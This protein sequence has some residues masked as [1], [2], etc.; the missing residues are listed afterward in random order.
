MAHNFHDNTGLF[1]VGVDGHVGLLMPLFIPTFFISVTAVHP[2]ILGA[3]QQPT[4]LMNGGHPSVQ[5][6]HNPKFLW[7]HI[8][9]IPGPMDAFTPLHCIFGEQQCWLPRLAVHICKKPAAPTVFPGPMSINLDCWEFAK[10]PTSLVLQIGTVQTTPSPDDYKYGLV[11]MAVEAAIDVVIW[12]AT[13]GHKGVAFTSKGVN[14]LVGEASQVAVREIMGEG[15]EHMGREGFDNIQDRM[16]DNLRKQAMDRF[17]SKVL[18]DKPADALSWAN[19]GRQI[20]QDGTGFN[21]GDF[22]AS[23]AT[24]QD[25]QLDPNL[26]K[27][28]KSAVNKFIPI[29]GP[30]MTGNDLREQQQKIG[31]EFAKQAKN[32][33]QGAP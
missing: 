3:D 1:L 30:V 23:L 26:G 24:G 2:F 14:K 27:G 9:V 7:P 20:L 4:V 25:F 21:P 18:L 11:R 28:V 12:F 17:I 6:K 10:L 15:L 19:R 29:T 13:G 16:I 32:Q 33:A 22:A 5:D 31:E 8:G